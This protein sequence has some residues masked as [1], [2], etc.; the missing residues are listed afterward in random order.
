MIISN[1]IMINGIWKTNFTLKLSDKL[2]IYQCILGL[3]DGFFMLPLYSLT[4]ILENEVRC[5]I[6][7]FTLFGIIH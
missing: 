7:L 6:A 5:P 2:Y 3:F 1:V 4:Q